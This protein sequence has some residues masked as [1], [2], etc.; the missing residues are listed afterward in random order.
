MLQMNSQ[1]AIVDNSG[2]LVGN[3]ISILGGK[4]FGT[5]GDRIVISLRKV[6]KGKHSNQRKI[7]VGKVY[8]ALIVQTV[9]GRQRND[10]STLQFSQNGVILLNAQDHPIGTRIKSPVPRELKTSPYLK[11]LSLGS[12]II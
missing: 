12:N 4:R 2:G 9:K 5:I 6:A 8:R 11:A 1:V 3:C 10:G 7:T